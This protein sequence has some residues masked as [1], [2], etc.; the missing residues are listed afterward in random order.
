MYSQNFKKRKA[1][2]MG[3][4]RYLFILLTCS[5]CTSLIAEEPKNKDWWTLFQEN[6]ALN[7]KIT[8]LENTI[9]STEKRILKLASDRTILKTKI[10]QLKTGNDELQSELSI[11]K[12]ENQQLKVGN[13]N[14][15]SAL[16]ECENSVTLKDKKSGNEEKIKTKTKI[17]PDLKTSNIAFPSPSIVKKK[18]FGIF[19]GESL[20]KINQR[21]QI[22]KSLFQFTDIDHPGQ[23][24]EVECLNP[25]IKRL[26][27]Y[28]Y[29]NYI[30]TIDVE[31]K[32]SSLANYEAI[33]KQLELKYK[34]SDKGGLTGALFGEGRFEVNISGVRVSIK[35]NRDIGFTDGDSLELH[36]TH[37]PLRNMVYKEQQRRK[38]TKVKDDL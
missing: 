38:A 19:L 16:N 23:I 14:L 34:S 2:K 29:N 27:I 5:L 25:D 6:K 9:K 18:M 10:R 35:L 24:W 33:K 3:I 4:K 13:D 37:T 26:L 17:K 12:V 36:Y 8:E 11:L 7:K 15:R 28:T 31:F 22:T 1:L 20:N 32:D 30:Y 21:R